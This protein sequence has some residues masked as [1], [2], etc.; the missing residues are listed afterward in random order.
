MPDRTDPPRL[1]VEIRG[2]FAS[3]DAPMPTILRDARVWVVYAYVDRVSRVRAC[4][5]AYM[6]TLRRALSLAHVF[7]LQVVKEVLDRDGRAPPVL[8][9]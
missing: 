9:S 1:R 7:G 8:L 5:C 3:L 2:A 6:H 4:A